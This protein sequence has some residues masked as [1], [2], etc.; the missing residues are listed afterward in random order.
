MTGKSKIGFWTISIII[1]IILAT[2]Y[3]YVMISEYNEEYVITNLTV[4]GYDEIIENDL[5]NELL[6]VSDNNKYGII[7]YNGNVIEDT[8]YDFNDIKLGY[9]NYYL[10]SDAN[11]NKLIKRYKKVIKDVTYL[12]DPYL[13]LKDEND[14]GQ[15]IIYV[16]EFENFA[17]LKLNDTTYIANIY[18]NGNYYTK[19][20]DINNGVIEEIN[21]YTSHVMSDNITEKYLINIEK[22]NVNLLNI[23]D[24]S[25]ILSNYDRIGDEENL[26]GYNYSG[27]IVNDNYIPVCNENKCGIVN[28]IGDFVIDMN[29]EDF[30]SIK[31]TNPKFIATKKDGKFGIINLEETLIIPFMYDNIYIF[32]D[33]F[34]LIKDNTLT[35]ETSSENKIY[36]TKINENTIIDTNVINDSYVIIKLKNANNN[37]EI[38]KIIV[39][40]NDNNLR[41]FN[42][43]EYIEIGNNT[44][45]SDMYYAIFHKENNELNIDFYNGLSIVNSYTIVEPNEFNGV[46]LTAIENDGILV[47]MNG[48][49]NNYYALIYTNSDEVI[50]TNVFKR[51]NLRK[52]LLGTY[53]DV[54]DNTLVYYQR[55]LISH[56]LEDNVMDANIVDKTN[57]KYIIKK[58]DNTVYLY[59]IDRR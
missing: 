25:P 28:S 53:V 11:G 7:D 21:G 24:Y 46:E 9:D 12:D 30:S 45:T 2:Y 36:S 57:N 52:D 26:S 22:N 3:G 55:D 48:K 43:Q 15:Y 6:M 51:V 17:T 50:T 39:V 54:E 20:L 49:I 38:N 29:Y 10:I 16:K 32:N 56:P 34:I 42:S 41:E 37:N 27:R 44:N 13:L 33:T 23:Y 18:E 4:N 59:L 5:D 35:I 47:K 58:L 31:E 1:I 14:N 8:V 19:F 40:D